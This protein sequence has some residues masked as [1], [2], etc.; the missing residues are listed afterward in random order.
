MVIKTILWFVWAIWIMH[1]TFELLLLSSSMERRVFLNG[2][3]NVRKVVLL[4]RPIQSKID[5][6][7]IYEVWLCMSL[8][9]KNN[10]LF[11][12]FVQ[13]VYIE[14]TRKIHT[15]EYVDKGNALEAPVAWRLGQIKRKLM[16]KTMLVLPLHS[17]IN[18]LLVCVLVLLL[19]QQRLLACLAHSLIQFLRHSVSHS[20][21]KCVF[22]R[23]GFLSEMTSI[24]PLIK[25]TIFD[26]GET[27][28]SSSLTIP[29]S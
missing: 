5:S 23:G 1:L 14:E 10:T 18:Q 11:Y 13:Q 21:C 7:G 8:R 17:R 27:I 16:F 3:H 22:K 2:S 29:H 6:L 4:G 15:V 24:L 28:I 12:T 25:P 19:P 26:T 9:L 20:V